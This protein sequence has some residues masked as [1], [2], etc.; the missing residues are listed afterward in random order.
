MPGHFQKIQT[1]GVKVSGKLLRIHVVDPVSGE[2]GTGRLCRLLTEEKI[3][4]VFLTIGRSGEH[5]VTSCCVDI[6]HETRVRKLIESEEM[7]RGR[8]RFTGAVGLLSMFPHQSQ[9]E[10]LGISLLALGA[11]NLPILDLSSSL[12]ALSFVLRYT[13]LETAVTALSQFFSFPKDSVQLRSTVHVR[14]A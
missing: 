2:K 9:L 14:Q 8:A 7:L 6:G 5:T 12:A 10:V 3:S 1:G 4:I 11:V 13:D